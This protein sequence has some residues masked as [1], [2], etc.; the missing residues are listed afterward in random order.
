MDVREAD[1]GWL[2]SVDV[3][4]IDLESLSV[5]H[6]GDEIV[7][8]ATTEDAR[9]EGWELVRRERRVLDMERRLRFA[10]PVDADGI[11]AHYTDGVLRVAVPRAR[12]TRIPITLEAT[13]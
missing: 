9:Q 1:E 6:E 3:P 10:R 7:L 8:R 4:G 12:T 2:I 5:T 11:Q 13:S